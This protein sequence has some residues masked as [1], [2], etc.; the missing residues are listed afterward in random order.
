LR[1]VKVLG[2]IPPDSESEMAQYALQQI[3][4]LEQEAIMIFPDLYSAEALAAIPAED[5]EMLEGSRQGS[6]SEGEQGEA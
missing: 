2:L 3:T 6:G 1:R 4:K 5:S